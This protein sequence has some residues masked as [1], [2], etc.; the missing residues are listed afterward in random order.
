MHKKYAKDGL[1]AISVSVDPLKDDEGKSIEAE[2]RAK[3]L[4]FLKKTDATLTN[5]LL[6]EPREL[7]QERLRIVGVPTVFVFNRAGQWHQFKG[8]DNSLKKDEKGHYFEVEALVTK[9]LAQK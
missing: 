2:E 8:D 9:L 3:V 7:W 5:L 6:D 4:K 1:V